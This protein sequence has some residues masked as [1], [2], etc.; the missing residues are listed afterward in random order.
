M[1][2]DPVSLVIPDP[3]EVTAGNAHDKLSEQLAAVAHLADPVAGLPASLEDVLSRLHS[4]LQT[5]ISKLDEVGS[6]SLEVGFPW[7]V[8][9]SVNFQ[10]VSPL[11]LGNP[12]DAH[13]PGQ[14]GPADG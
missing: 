9:V 12:D 8:S 13:H 3:G 7:G 11:P 14:S 4:N 5:I 1:P 6:W 10:S 2:T